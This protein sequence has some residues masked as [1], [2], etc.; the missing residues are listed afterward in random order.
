MTYKEK[1]FTHIRANRPALMR[2]EFGCEI[3]YCGEKLRFVARQGEDEIMRENYLCV[4]LEK[5]SP[6][7]YQSQTIIH[8]DKL[9]I[10]GHPPQLNDVLAVLDEKG[11]TYG[12]YF[13]H[14]N[15]WLMWEETKDGTTEI[16]QLVRLPLTPP[17]EWD[18]DTCQQL[19]KLL[20]I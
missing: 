15:G 12:S 1:L 2:L 13:M 17:S 6:H 20:N 7:T 18:E 8:S 4:S 9:V 3:D 19:C 5:T 14:A 16:K 10:I 11:T